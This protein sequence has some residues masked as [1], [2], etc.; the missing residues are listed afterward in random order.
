[1]TVSHVGWMVTWAVRHRN[2]S[3]L[4]Q[5]P[6]WCSIQYRKDARAGPVCVI[7]VQVALMSEVARA[8]A[9]VDAHVGVVGVAEAWLGFLRNL[10]VEITNRVRCRLSDWWC[11]GL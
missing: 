8:R 4:Q 3:G 11:L 10:A 5:T 6:D 7:T 9:A 1:V 2:C